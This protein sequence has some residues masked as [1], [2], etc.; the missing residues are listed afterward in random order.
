ME[1]R[2]SWRKKPGRKSFKRNFRN[3]TKKSHDTLT[4]TFPD[5]S[6]K[7]TR[8]NMNSFNGDWKSLA[9]SLCEGHRITWTTS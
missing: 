8:P 2:L 4:I 7:V 5:G 6:V 3:K 1:N 9:I